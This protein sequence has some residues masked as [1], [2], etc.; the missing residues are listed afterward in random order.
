MRLSR[1]VTRV[2]RVIRMSN[3]CTCIACGNDQGRAREGSPAPVCDDCWAEHIWRNEAQAA[4]GAAYVR[5]T[6]R[7]AG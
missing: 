1:S 4:V 2:L 7:K 5:A 6:D 3:K